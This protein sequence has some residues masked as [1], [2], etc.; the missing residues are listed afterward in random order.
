M[1]HTFLALSALF[2]KE[3][4][5]ILM[6]EKPPA[7]F[8]LFVSLRHL[9]VTHFLLN[10]LLEELESLWKS[11]NKHPYMWHCRHGI[12]SN[13]WGNTSLSGYCMNTQQRGVFLSLHGM[14]ELQYT[15]MEP[16]YISDS[17]AFLSL[18]WCWPHC[19][20][21]EET[22]FWA[23][24][25]AVQADSPQTDVRWTTAGHGEAAQSQKVSVLQ[26]P[27]QGEHIW[28]QDHFWLS[29]SSCR[30]R[31]RH[32]FLNIHLS[33]TWLKILAPSSS[34][35]SRVWDSSSV[36]VRWTALWQYL[37]WSV[38]GPPLR[39][40]FPASIMLMTLKSSGL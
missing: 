14:L 5:P 3:Q 7:I 27:G 29:W 6:L 18:V 25:E 2:I 13:T 36:A 21:A 9:G 15:S 22:L 4:L 40:P 30:R 23:T 33:V 37:I 16:V 39:H 28:P 35:R 32:L 38:A 19:C 10:R 11:P 24:V 8:P 34:T 20:Q 1:N 17:V 31:Q 26:Q 12:V